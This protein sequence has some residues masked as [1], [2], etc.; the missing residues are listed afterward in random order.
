MG[1]RPGARSGQETKAAAAPPRQAS[2]PGSCRGASS[3]R[4]R[5]GA[6]GS[7]VI[8][9]LCVATGLAA[10][11][12]ALLG[13]GETQEREAPAPLPHGSINLAREV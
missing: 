11:G 9:Q 4:G 5:G 2:K 12:P 8:A 6:V 7:G 13:A 1:T 3:L 10:Q